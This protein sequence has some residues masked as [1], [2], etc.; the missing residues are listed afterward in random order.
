M[1]TAPTIGRIVHYRLTAGDAEQINRRRAD[2]SN[3]TAAGSTLASQELGAQIHVG[4]SVE[5][6][7]VYPATIVRVWDGSA[8]VN[9]Q[10]ALDGSDTYWATSRQEG[11]D[12][13]QWA[14]P[15]RS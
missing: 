4:N 2:A 5:Q 11:D 3:L 10:V 9:L 12:E 13:G 1:T 7:Q 8:S 15:T 14:W 6:G